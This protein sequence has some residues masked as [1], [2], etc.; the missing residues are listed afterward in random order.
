[1][2]ASWTI[3]A[4]QNQRANKHR[5]DITDEHEIGNRDITKS[6]T[7]AIPLATAINAT[8]PPIRITGANRNAFQ[9]GMLFS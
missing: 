4:K 3:F 7:K 2:L 6:I 9:N 5:I 1:M 8:V